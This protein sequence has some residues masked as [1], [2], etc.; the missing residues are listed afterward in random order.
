[1]LKTSTD[2]AR[3]ERSEI[4]DQ[5]PNEFPGFRYALSGLRGYVVI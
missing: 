1:M 2:V 3:I 4:R 5:N